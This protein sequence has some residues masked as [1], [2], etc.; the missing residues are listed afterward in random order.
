MV[1]TAAASTAAVTTMGQAPAPHAA[2]THAVSQTVAAVV[3]PWTR[4]PVGSARITPPPRKPIP[5]MIPCMTRLAAA[6]S[7]SVLWVG[8]WLARSPSA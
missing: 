2:P 5:V 4:F 6:M 3:K 1:N 8:N 7:M